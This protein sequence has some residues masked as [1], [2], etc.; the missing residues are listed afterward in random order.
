MPELIPFSSSVMAEGP[1]EF[2]L[3]KIQNMMIKSLYDFSKKAYLKY[4]YNGL[5][6][7][8]WLFTYFA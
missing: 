7:D 8:E 5:E 2:W 3:L 1:V 6:R 4:P